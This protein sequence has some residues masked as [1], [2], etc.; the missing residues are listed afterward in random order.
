LGALFFFG[1]LMAFI[2][3]IKQECFQYTHYPLRFNRKTQ[4]MYL[5]RR[6]GSV[7]VAPWK[8]LYF[9]EMPCTFGRR[10]VSILIIE[11]NRKRSYLREKAKVLECV[12]LPVITVSGDRRGLF[13]FFE[14]VR[15]YMTGSDAKVAELAK[16]IDYAPDII[17]RRE[18]FGEGFHYMYAHDTGGY[19]HLKILSF[20]TTLLYSI[21]R[22]IAMHTCKIP[23]WPEEIEQECQ[24]EPDDPNLRDAWHLSQPGEARKPW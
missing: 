5:L 4:K 3:T 20:P 10:G 6:D 2:G 8:E 11:K 15:I 22:W 24:I 7:L 23:R 13:A 21:G 19:L 17:D 18:S 9:I 16:Q 12:H 14:F 1:I